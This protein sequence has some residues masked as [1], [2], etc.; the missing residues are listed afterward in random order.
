MHDKIEACT[1]KKTATFTLQDDKTGSYSQLDNLFSLCIASLSDGGDTKS[2]IKRLPNLPKLR[3]VFSESQGTSTNCYRF[4]GLEL[5]K[6]LYYSRALNNGELKLPSSLKKLTLSNFRL[7]WDH[8]S[9][10]G[11]L[12]NL[13]VLKLLSRAFEGSKVGHERREFHKLK[14][15]KLHSL[16]IAKWDASGDHLPSYNGHFCEIASNLRRFLAS[17]I[18][19]PCRYLKCNGVESPLKSL[20]ERSRRKELR[21][22][23]VFPY[24]S[25]TIGLVIVI[26]IVDET[27]YSM[28]C[29]LN[30]MD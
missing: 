17:W 16:S 26:F 3:C 14:F 29:D 12:Q 6:I 27:F 7:P 24:Q 2:I 1:H 13:E 23:G 5:L 25:F 21:G 11:R 9:I 15:L 8:I 19:P 30:F 10:I 4:P 28:L 18:S 22:L 20:S